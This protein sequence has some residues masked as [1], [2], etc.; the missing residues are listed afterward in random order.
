M[1]QREVY[2]TVELRGDSIDETWAAW[3]R[4]QALAIAAVHVKRDS[5]WDRDTF[6]AREFAVADQLEARKATS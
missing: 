3:W 4:A 2:R 6:V 5:T 1:L